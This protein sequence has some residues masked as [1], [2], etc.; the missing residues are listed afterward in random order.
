MVAGRDCHWR[1]CRL[2]AGSFHGSRTPQ[3]LWPG[4]PQH[5]AC[6]QPQNPTA[7]SARFQHHPFLPST[8]LVGDVTLLRIGRYI[9]SL[10]HN[11]VRNCSTSRDIF[12]PNLQKRFSAFKALSLEQKSHVNSDT[13]IRQTRAAATLHLM[14]RTCRYSGGRPFTGRRICKTLAFSAADWN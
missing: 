4:I 10:F 12:T 7:S 8:Q 2:V 5:S 3:R 14:L 11:A 6:S 13:Y 9:S 1:S